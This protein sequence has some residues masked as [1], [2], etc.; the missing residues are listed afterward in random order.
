MFEVC[1]MYPIAD[2]SQAQIAS[3]NI[4][5]SMF[6]VMS[7]WWRES[8]QLQDLIVPV[9]PKSGCLFPVSKLIM[10]TMSVHTL[11]INV[12]CQKLQV[13]H[14]LTIATITILRWLQQWHKLIGWGKLKVIVYHHHL[15]EFWNNANFHTVHVHAILPRPHPLGLEGGDNKLAMN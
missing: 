3:M 2:W 8:R 15:Y 11:I 5:W 14:S 1:I 12:L 7:A 13:Q 9:M 10:A 4:H 6:I